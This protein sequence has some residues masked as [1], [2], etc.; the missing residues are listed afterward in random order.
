MFT[1]NLKYCHAPEETSAER[2][3]R[4]SRMLIARREWML[5]YQPANGVLCW[6]E[7]SNERAMSAGD[8]KQWPD[9][10]QGK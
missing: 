10:S 1:L 2:G 7:H 6:G 5:Q 4:I 8:G 9:L 3:W